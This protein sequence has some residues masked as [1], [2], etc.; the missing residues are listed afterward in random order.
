MTP[1]TVIAPA[2]QVL[3]PPN[4]YSPGGKMKAGQQAPA[5][6]RSVIADSWDGAEMTTTDKRRKACK[7]LKRAEGEEG[8]GRQFDD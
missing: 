4:V 6:R 5:H 2:T 3:T 8:E 7:T 1:L